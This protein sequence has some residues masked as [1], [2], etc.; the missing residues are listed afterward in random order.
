LKIFKFEINISSF[1][2][3]FSKKIKIF[4]IFLIAASYRD[5]ILHVSLFIGVAFVFYS[6]QQENFNE[7]LLK[8]FEKQNFS[9]YFF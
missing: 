9:L 2:K 4:F 8:K 5:V 6:I 3:P 1:S 7:N